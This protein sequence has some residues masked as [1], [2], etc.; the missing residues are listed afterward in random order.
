MRDAVGQN[1]DDSNCTRALD[2]MSESSDNESINVRYN[3]PY[4]TIK[5]E[6]AE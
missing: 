2:N 5:E 4:D 6:D 3:N 1:P